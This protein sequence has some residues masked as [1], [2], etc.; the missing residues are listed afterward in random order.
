MGIVN[1]NSGVTIGNVS[2]ST[3][4]L[5]SFDAST[6]SPDFIYLG[7]SQWRASDGTPSATFNGSQNFTLHDQDTISD[8]GGVRRVTIFKLVAPAHVVADIVVTWSGGVDEAVIGATAWSGVDQA[9]PLG[10]SQKATSAGGVDTLSVNVTTAVGN[11]IHDTYSGSADGS[12]QSATTQTLRWRQWAAANTTEGGGATAA[13]TGSAVTMNWNTIGFGGAAANI[14]IVLLG[15]PINVSSGGT[16]ISPTGGALTLS[17]ATP[18][19]VLGTV[20]SPTG[21]ALVLAGGTPTRIDLGINPTGAALTLSGKTPI[22]DLALRPTGGSVVL[23]GSTPGVFTGVTVVPGAGSLTLSGNTALMA[24]GLPVTGGVLA[25]SGATPQLVIGTV[26]APSGA[27]LGLTGN[28]PLMG[29]GMVVSSSGVL[30]ITGGTPTTSVPVSVSPTGGVL[31]LIGGQPTIVIS[32]SAIFARLIHVS[33]E[34]GTLFSLGSYSAMIL[35]DGALDYWPMGDAGPA[36]IVDSGPGGHNVTAS[37]NASFGASGPVS[38]VTAIQFATNNSV[39]GSISI[40]GLTAFSMEAWVN[41]GG[42]GAAGVVLTMTAGKQ[43]SISL[44]AGGAVSI[45][46]IVNNV[47]KAWTS[48]GA[49]ALTGWHHIAVIWTTGETAKLYIDG[50]FDSESNVALSGVLN[51]YSTIYLGSSSGSTPFLQGYLGQVALYNL[52]LSAAQVSAHYRQQ[53]LWYAQLLTVSFED[54]V[55]FVASDFPF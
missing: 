21:A 36:T 9:T 53:W 3:L 54:R 10:T 22:W 39:S 40:S 12:L 41:M 4:T 13:G 26:R 33:A 23:A 24:L 45:G 50:V 37:A 47:T 29:L 28:Q 8:S 42:L 7:V 16:S 51:T 14:R 49:I 38:G 31:A 48:V 6:G 30:T 34:R 44:S 35:R 43:T 46:F 32:G 15:T 25:L 55:I 20:R 17:G 52:K 1:T 11:V 5:S 19:L 2:V 27:A 18:Q